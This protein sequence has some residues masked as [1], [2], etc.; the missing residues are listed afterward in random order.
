MKVSVEE[1]LVLFIGGFMILVVVAFAQMVR[2][3]IR[4]RKKK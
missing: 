3:E 4:R 1:I 2:Y